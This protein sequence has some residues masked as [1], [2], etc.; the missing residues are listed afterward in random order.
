VTPPDTPRAERTSERA[1]THARLLVGI[2]A[3]TAT[4]LVINASAQIKDSNFVFLW[5]A[6]S[7]LF[8]DR[9]YRE[10]FEWGAPLAAYLSAAMQWLVGYRLIGEFLLHWAFIVAGVTL[11]FHTGIRLSRSIVASLMVLPIVLLLLS[12]TPTYHYTKLFFFPLIIWLA[13]RYVEAPGVARSVALGVATALGFLFR[14]DFALYLAV[15]S[16]LAVVIGCAVQHPSRSFRAF[17]ID[18]ASGAAAAL[19][20]LL[21]WAIAVERTEGLF[22][23]AA[24][25][26]AKYEPAPPPYRSLLHLN[27][28]RELRPARPPAPQ[29]GVVTFR[30]NE[31]LGE[32]QRRAIEQRFGMQRLEERDDA[33]RFK[34]MVPNLFD[35]RLLSLDPYI[36]DGGGFKWEELRELRDRLPSG[37]NVA[38]WLL[39]IAVLVPL[40]LV[41][42]AAAEARRCWRQSQTVSL[43]VWNMAIAGVFLIVVDHLLLRE[44]SYIVAVAPQT[45]ALSAS[46]LAA[47]RR[48][49]AAKPRIWPIARRVVA[50]LVL[51]VTT[52]V[53]A[54]E[55]RNVPMFDRSGW[56]D[57]FRSAYRQ[58]TISP[59]V[60][61]NPEALYLYECTSPGDHLLI[62][63]TTPFD[64]NYYAERPIAGGH[65]Y[66]HSRWGAD[67]PHERLS[68]ALLERQS[69]PFVVANSDP[70]MEDFTAYPAIRAYLLQHYADV[71]GT[72]GRILADTRRQPK[73]QWGDRSWPCFR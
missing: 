61:G 70:V 62:T 67:P 43:R 52:V 22:A 11:A 28:L 39:Q 20:C 21:P 73:R 48:D 44:P 55:A 42:S 53:A 25:R 27:P 45:A 49:E 14:H 36:A 66:W 5:E 1:T 40:C 38:L 12:V 58:L 2:A 54:I 4:I 31:Q 35:V 64:I 3:I 15:A 65:L 26:A 56:F 72:G 68:L 18:A 33:G 57:S 50:T 34:Y 6:A 41:L 10:L 17:S 71:G 32:G 46:F 7:L 9:P 60:A 23:Y 30:W 69:V 29:P 19:V 13:W 47:R 24:L 51:L 16:V 8:G 63:G 37:E 59:P